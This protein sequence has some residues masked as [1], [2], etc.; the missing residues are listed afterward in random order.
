MSCSDWPRLTIAEC[1]SDEPYSTQIGP[2]GKALMANEYVESGVPVLRGV[3]I[4]RERFVDDSF[5]FIDETTADRLSKFESLPGDVLLVHKG[6]VGQ[7]GLM[8]QSRKHPRYIMGNSM[9]RVRCN[10]SKMIPEYL[11]YW[12]S[13][14]EGQHYL[15]G[16]MSQ[17][18]VPQLQTPLTTLRQASLPVPPLCEQRR[19]VSILSTL[20]EKIEL[21]RRMNRTLESTARAVFKSWFVDFDSAETGGQA[22]GWDE[23]DLSDV[24]D[25][26]PESWTATNL[27]GT[28]AY[29]DLSNVKRGRIESVAAFDRDKAPSRAR[30]RLRRGDTV[31]GLVRPGNESFALI[32]ESGL[33]GSTGFAVL[34]PKRPEYRE[35]VYLAATARASILE[36]SSLADG[37][38]YPAVRPDVVAQTPVVLPPVDVA[39]AFSQ[40]TGPLLDFFAVCER[41]SKRLVA[42][43]DT[44]LPR[45]MSGELVL[46]DVT[47]A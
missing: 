8:P 9:M 13:S 26:N 32:S 33:T 30:R 47:A 1:A 38:A 19:I 44:L 25:L 27:P 37:G 46:G 35:F 39:R 28:V 12:L 34:R 22:A 3:N 42:V 15:Y 43:R 20:D 23:G 10:P 16:R 29:L 24:A 14:G 4:S 45:L 36:L 5:V 21:N 6:T 31:V 11:Y 7:V 2:F 17:V 41:Q 40:L 18:G